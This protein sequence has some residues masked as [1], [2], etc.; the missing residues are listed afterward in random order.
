[1]LRRFPSVQ[2]SIPSRGHKLAR[3]YTPDRRVDQNPRAEMHNNVKVSETAAN[4][5]SK[6]QTCYIDLVLQS[7]S[8]LRMIF[9]LIK[10]TSLGQSLYGT[11]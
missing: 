9:L 7:V 8:F 11:I 3:L 6:G 2:E 5:A 1:M 10:L 4:G